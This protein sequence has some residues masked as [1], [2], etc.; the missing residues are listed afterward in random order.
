MPVTPDWPILTWDD[1]EMGM[2]PIPVNIILED[3]LLGTQVF[4]KYSWIVSDNATEKPLVEDSLEIDTIIFTSDFDFV[5]TIEHM[6][7]SDIQK[8]NV[9]ADLE[10]LSRGE[11]WELPNLL[12]DEKSK[13]F[14]VD[15]EP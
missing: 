4:V 13:T 3:P 9:D 2:N 8:V 1:K 15:K 7:E 5:A 10:N 12:P 14:P 11:Y 6:D